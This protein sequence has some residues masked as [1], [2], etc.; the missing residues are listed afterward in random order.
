MKDEKEKL[1]GQ[2]KMQFLLY[3][4]L[5]FLLMLFV[6]AYAYI[7]HTEGSADLF[8]AVNAVSHFRIFCW[9]NPVTWG[10]C[11]KWSV[12]YWLGI[13]MFLIYEEKWAH[14]MDGTENGSAHWNNKV[15]EYNETHAEPFGEKTFSDEPGL[16][17]KMGGKNLNNPKSAPVPGNPNM[18]ESATVRLS[19]A[20]MKTHLNNNV[21]IVGGAGT[22]KSRFFIKPNVLQM[23]CSYVVTDPSGELLKSMHNVLADNGYK[24]KV[25]NLVDMSHSCKYNPFKYV[26]SETD[27]SILVDCFIS[28]TTAPDQKS[29]DP[30]WD[31]SEKALLS[32][33]I[34]YLVDIADEKFKKFS[35]ILW[36]VQLAQ[37][38]ENGRPGQKPSSKFGFSLDMPLDELF[39]GTKKIVEK[40]VTDKYGKK[41]MVLDAAEVS[42]PKEIEKLQERIETSLCLT[43]YKT[44][45]LGGTKTLKSILISAAVRLNPFSIPAIKNLTDD[46]NVELESVG[47]VLTCFF[48]IIPQTNSTFNFLI[49]ML[50]SQMFESLYYKGAT[51]PN[52]RLPYHV[53]FLLD[54]FANI[55]KIPEFPQKISTCRKYNISTTIVL[56]SIAQIKMLYKDDYETIIGNCDTAICLGTNEQTTAD[57]FSKKLGVGTIRVKNSSK[58]VGKSGANISINKSKRELMLPDEIMTMPFDECIVMMNHISPFYDKKYPLETHPQFKFTGDGDESNFYFLEDDPEFLCVDKEQEYAEPVIKEQFENKAEEKYMPKTLEEVLG[59]LLINVPEDD[60]YFLIRDADAEADKEIKRAI[61]MNTLDDLEYAIEQSIQDEYKTALF[62]DANLEPTILKQLA[63]K[64]MSE[65]ADQINDIVISC[66]GVGSNRLC[67]S[68]AKDEDCNIIKVAEKLQIDMKQAKSKKQRCFNVYDIGSL[69]PEKYDK[70]EEG[71]KKGYQVIVS[72]GNFANMDD[73]FDDYDDD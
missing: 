55:G 54:E 46:D 32:S 12:I 1:Q 42:D 64:A 58:S 60:G 30:F 15:E 27:V 59:D 22:G 66:D 19:T 4:M 16:T 2:R 36:M 69:T 38:D 10:K 31:K 71:C 56:Q 8:A 44:F 41:Q 47:D 57:Y 14:D 37:M 6:S 11:I 61:Y 39:N 70:L 68:A 35:T 45:K 65:Y 25:F 73:D 72:K 29:G 23:N 67:A 20:D 5:W 48:A 33:L 26:R 63:T 3:G 21:F 43:N 50:F 52:S 9:L 17:K 28:N 13:A 34:F 49:S 40:E 7:E 24:I 62:Y 51:I 53:R 18:I